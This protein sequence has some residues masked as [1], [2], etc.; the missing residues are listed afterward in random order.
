MT[1]VMCVNQG[2]KFLTRNVTIRITD[3][4]CYIKLHVILCDLRF[5]EKVMN[6]GTN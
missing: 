1:A 2:W 3:T 6:F 5:Y 4:N